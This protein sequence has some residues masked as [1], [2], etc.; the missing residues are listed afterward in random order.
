MARNS[1]RKHK[2]QAD[3]FCSCIKKV[4]KTIRLRP[5]QSK[6]KQSKESAAIGTCVK[7]VLQTRGKTL[8]KFGC[9]KKP[10]LQTQKMK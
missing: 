4:R 5:G 9:E 3:K 10:F 7:A 2:T 1:T 8:K 6:T